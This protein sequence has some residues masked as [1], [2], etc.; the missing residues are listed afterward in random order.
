MTDLDGGFNPST[1]RYGPGTPDYAKPQ[2]YQELG[3]TIML[4]VKGSF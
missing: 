3:S 2:R 1:L 4:G